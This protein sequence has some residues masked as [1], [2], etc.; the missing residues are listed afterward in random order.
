MGDTGS[1][2][3]GYILGVTAVTFTFIPVGAASR[4]A[5]F[6]VALPF[7]LFAIPFYDTLSVICI[8]IR[9]G[10]HPFSADKRHFSHRLTDL[11]MTRREAVI[12]IYVATLTTAFPA[13]YLYHLNTYS[14]LGAVAQALF[15]LLLVAMLEHAG[16]RKNRTT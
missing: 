12:T 13:L 7:I 10:R 15:V 1:Y 5:L 14:L 4:A 2:F 16:A 3:L 8:R 11:G 6:P 9:E